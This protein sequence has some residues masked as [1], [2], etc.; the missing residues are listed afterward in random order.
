MLVRLGP[1]LT[2]AHLSFQEFLTARDLRDPQ[3][4]RPKQ[5]LGWYLNGQ[6]WWKESLAFY[7]T[8]SDRPGDTDE[9]IIKRA[10]ESN[11]TSADLKWRV[12]YLRNAIKMAFPAYQEAS[13]AR[14]LFEKL[15]RKLGGISS[16]AGKVQ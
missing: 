13:G 14:T 1:A 5:A 7:A 10:L 6:D 9:W 16:A 12:N 11:A 2:F 4:T 3:G 8:L 15:E